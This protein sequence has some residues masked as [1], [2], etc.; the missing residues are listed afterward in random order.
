MQE[1]HNIWQLGCE[2]LASLL[3]LLLGLE[4]WKRRKKERDSVVRRVIP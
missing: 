1:N 3:L 4:I 2:I